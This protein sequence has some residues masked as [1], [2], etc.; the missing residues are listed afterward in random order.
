MTVILIIIGSLIGAGFASGQEIYLF[1]YRYGKNGI[2]GLFICCILIGIIIYKTFKIITNKNITDYKRFLEEIL[3]NKKI[4]KIVNL[5]INIFLLITFYIMISGFGAYFEQEFNIN[6]NIGA[7]IVSFICYL[8]LIKNISGV[9]KIS[10]I[11]VPI[12]IICIIY[13]SVQNAIQMQYNNIA[14]KLTVNYGNKYSWIIQ[15]IL[16]CSYNMILVIPI[17]INIKKY[18]KGKKQILIISILTSTIILILS[19]SVY[20][21]LINVDIDFNKIDMPIVYVISQN[22]SSFKHI[23]G[24]II[25]IAIFTTAISAGISFIENV[26][27]NK[28][29]YPHIVAIM[30]I[31][32]CIISNFGFSNLVK[33][34]FPAFG[35]L[36]LIQILNI[37]FL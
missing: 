11:V 24:I 26:V 13:I 16:Y 25:L 14:G 35:Y 1:F 31:T 19:L 12:L 27:K 34:L 15:S 9:A 29:N 17:L 33:I 6:H 5:T 28:R 2:I 7:I 21:L 10:S 20:F 8:A 23:Y 18:I 32:G 4:S 36:G 3:K 37:I 22:F 30:C